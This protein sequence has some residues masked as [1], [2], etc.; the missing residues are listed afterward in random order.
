M[1]LISMA[2]NMCEPQSSTVMEEF[3]NIKTLTE[4]LA[5]EIFKTIEGK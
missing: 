4:A 1:N 3:P 5:I 2:I